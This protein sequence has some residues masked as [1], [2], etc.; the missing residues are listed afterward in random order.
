MKN[1][2]SIINACI[3]ILV[4]TVLTAIVLKFE[5]SSFYI[6][7]IQNSQLNGNTNNLVNE[8]KFVEEI[9]RLELLLS[10]DKHSFESSREEL[11]AYLKE[12]NL[13]AKNITYTANFNKEREEL[14]ECIS[15][16]SSENKL[17]NSCA[18]KYMSKIAIKDIR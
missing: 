2:S 15:A 5:K 13:I 12:S 11:L 14:L 8:V 10:N 6:V 1:E 16:Y 3:F 18:R 9:K 17:Y 4:A 7:H